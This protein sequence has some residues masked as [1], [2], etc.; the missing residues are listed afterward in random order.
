LNL[1]IHAADRENSTLVVKLRQL[2]KA[3]H[4]DI[5]ALQVLGDNDDY[6]INQLTAE[7][8]CHQKELSHCSLEPGEDWGGLSYA[9]TIRGPTLIPYFTCPFECLLYPYYINLDFIRCL[10]GLLRSPLHSRC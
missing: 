4:R 8:I 3:N 10:G 9:N 5:L 1:Q 2:L 7:T 6:Y